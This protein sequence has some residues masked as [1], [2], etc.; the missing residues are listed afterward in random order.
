MAK[1]EL[2]LCLGRVWTGKIL[3]IFVRNSVKIS[4]Q[5]TA[6]VYEGKTLGLSHI[7]VG[8]SWCPEVVLLRAPVQTGE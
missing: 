4:A 2:L 3:N 5:W 6:T 1:T 7:S 8:G